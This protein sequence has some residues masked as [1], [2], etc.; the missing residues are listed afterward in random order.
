MLQY[1]YFSFVTTIIR[2]RLF[3]R[4]F[5]MGIFGSLRKNSRIGILKIIEYSE[6][7]KVVFPNYFVENKGPPQFLQ[8]SLN[9]HRCV[10]TVMASLN[11][12]VIRCFIYVPFIRCSIYVTFS[13]V[14]HMQMQV[15]TLNRRESRL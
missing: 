5:V 3:F 12:Y 13:C 4:S 1:Y 14:C 7:H 15:T 10:L 6:Q 11:F 9:K 8:N 2:N